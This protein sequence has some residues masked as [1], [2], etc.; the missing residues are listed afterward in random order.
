[1]IQ[2]LWTLQSLISFQKEHHSCTT[3]CMELNSKMMTRTS[4]TKILLMPAMVVFNKK[5]SIEF[6]KTVRTSI[7]SWNGW[8]SLNNRGWRQSLGVML[9]CSSPLKIDKS[10]CKNQRALPSKLRKDWFLPWFS[11]AIHTAN[12]Q[13]ACKATTENQMTFSPPYCTLALYCKTL[14][15]LIILL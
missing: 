3:S 6:S 14:W 9:P 8:P 15:M 10:W 12:A 1:M 11:C 7:C 5:T 4:T 13:Q 2:Y